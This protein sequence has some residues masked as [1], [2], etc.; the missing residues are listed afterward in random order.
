MKKCRIIRNGL[1]LIRRADLT[2]NFFERF[3]GLM[4]ADSIPDAYGLVISPCRQIH[5]FN[6]KFPL[7]VIY[8]SADNKV[9]AVDENMRPWS[10][11]KTVK[12]AAK[13]LEVNVGTCARCGIMPGDTFEIEP[14]TADEGKS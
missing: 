5:M 9:V 8:L 12:T 11:G 10:V 3:R 4:F 2:E 13:V 7:D 14:I 1:V 6:M